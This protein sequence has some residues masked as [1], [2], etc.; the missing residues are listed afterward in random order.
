M[1][2]S[3]LPSEMEIVDTFTKLIFGQA[4]ELSATELTVTQVLRE[5]DD[6]VCFDDLAEMG[7]YLRALGVQEMIS[8]VGRVRRH[9][10]PQA[11]SGFPVSPP[12]QLQF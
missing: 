4:G 1:D 2:E 7:V 5:V 10:P 11:G 6:N 12:A 9:Y 3:V 8:L